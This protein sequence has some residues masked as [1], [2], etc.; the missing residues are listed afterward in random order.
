MSF[1]ADKSLMKHGNTGSFLERRDCHITGGYQSPNQNSH[2]HIIQHLKKKHHQPK[3]QQLKKNKLG[4]FTAIQKPNLTP[5]KNQQNPSSTQ[6]KNVKTNIS[7]KINMEPEN[8][9]EIPIKNHH[10]EVPC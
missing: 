3:K 1:L 9:K 8:G 6:K 2:N 5:N 7:C 4:Y 10:C